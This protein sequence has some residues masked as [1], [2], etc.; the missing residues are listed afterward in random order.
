MYDSV[1]TKM[2]AAIAKYPTVAAILADEVHG[3]WCGNEEPIDA[4]LGSDA[5]LSQ[6]IDV[7][8]AAV[9]NGGKWFRKNAWAWLQLL[10]REQ[11]ARVRGCDAQT[12]Y[13]CL[14]W[15]ESFRKAGGQVFWACQGCEKGKA[16]DAEMCDPGQP[17]YAPIDGQTGGR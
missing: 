3:G 17:R 14:V 8:S 7:Y 2:D 6:A 15:Q 11:G 12:E 4:I 16:H 5:A 13:R 10:V 1:Q 9:R